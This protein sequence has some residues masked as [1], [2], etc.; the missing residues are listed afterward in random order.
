M[1]LKK[2]DNY[3]EIE[4]NQEFT[5]LELGGHKGIIKKVEE[6]TSEISGNTSLKVEVDTDKTDKQPNYYQ[7]QFDNDTRSDKKWNNGATKY[8]SLKEEENCVRMLKAFITAVE[9]SNPN[10][11]YDWSKDIKQLDGK[12]VGLVFGWEEYQDQEGK[13]K[14]ATKLTQF[15]SLDK[16]DEIKIPKVKKLDGTFVDYEE[17]KNHKA[18]AIAEEIFGSSIVETDKGELPFDDFEI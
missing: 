6:Y 1:I 15:R 13:I 16:V 5:P 18:T 11:T 2:A 14:T 12:K 17:Y 10:F 3:D 8:V 9:N 4:V 7:E